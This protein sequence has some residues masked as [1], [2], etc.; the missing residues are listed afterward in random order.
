MAKSKADMLHEHL[1]GVVEGLLSW[2]SDTKNSF[3]AK[4]SVATRI[5]RRETCNLLRFGGKN[6]ELS[7]SLLMTTWHTCTSTFGPT[8]PRPIDSAH[9]QLNTP[10]QDGR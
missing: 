7:L 1:K 6:L 8:G 4:V 3:K 9:I 5:S 10:P 2:Q